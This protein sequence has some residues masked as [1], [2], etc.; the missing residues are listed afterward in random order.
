MKCHHNLI[1][2]ILIPVISFLSFKSFSLGLWGVSPVFSGIL[3]PVGGV[4][5]SSLEEEKLEMKEWSL[6]NLRIN[7]PQYNPFIHRLK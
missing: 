1:L 3:Q 6:Q 2:P 7:D 5:P 4:K